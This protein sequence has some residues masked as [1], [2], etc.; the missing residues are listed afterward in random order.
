MSK[1]FI[2]NLPDRA[3]GED[4]EDFLGR[5]GRIREISL[6]NGYGLW[7]T[8]ISH[9]ILSKI[10]VVNSKKYSSNLGFVEF[11]DTR[12]ADDAVKE[13]NGERLCGERV[14]IEMAHGMALV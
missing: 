8:G 10:H 14:T 3:R 6:K 4:V 12:D 5:Y 2:G 7:N 1:V 11:E 13:L 9:A